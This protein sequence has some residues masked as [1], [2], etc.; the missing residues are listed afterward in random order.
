[1][2][3]SFASILS[4]FRT[5]QLVILIL[6]SVKSFIFLRGIGAQAEKDVKKLHALATRT[7]Y[8]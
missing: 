8:L 3:L 4:D 1:M 7:F 6:F 2:P 5:T